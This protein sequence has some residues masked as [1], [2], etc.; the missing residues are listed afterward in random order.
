MGKVIATYSQDKSIEVVTGHS[1]KIKL[2]QETLKYD[3][4]EYFRFSLKATIVSNG[5]L[6]RKFSRINKINAQLRVGEIVLCN[7]K[8]FNLNGRDCSE[9]RFKELELSRN[10]LLNLI[11]SYG[12]NFENSKEME[13]KKIVTL[14]YKL[15]K[16]RMPVPI[17]LM[18]FTPKFEQLYTRLNQLKN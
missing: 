12:L 4:H 7:G 17:Y 5:D 2:T 18:P 9:P 1:D 15:A 3:L 13:G 14:G 11:E 8:I 10:G 16:E 6:L